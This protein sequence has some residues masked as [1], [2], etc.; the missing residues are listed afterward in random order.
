M[1]EEEIVTETVTDTDLNDNSKELAALVAENASMKSKMDELLTEAKRAKQAKRDIEAES[2]A[3]RER[4][5]KEQGD[6]QQ[7]HK[8]A[9]EKY[10]STL[11]ELDSLRQGVANEK[12]N[13]TALKLAA[14]LADGANA[15]ILSEFIGRRLKFHDD[16]VKVTDANGSLTVSSFEDLKNEFKNDARYAALLKGNQSSGGGASG[17]SNSGGATKVRSRAEF[18]AL[19]PVKRMEFVKSGGTITDN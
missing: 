13:N 18:E 2:T 15:E 1:S 19:N 9:Q 17:G 8:S 7:L 10:E 12:K 16:G 6:Y 4:V 14:D 11:T 5:A 3:E